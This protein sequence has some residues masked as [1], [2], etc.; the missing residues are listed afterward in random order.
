MGR[1]WTGRRCGSTLGLGIANGMTAIGASHRTD[2]AL[3]GRLVEG[4]MRRGGIFYR[5]GSGALMLAHVAAG[6]L[7]AISS[8]TC[9][10][11]TASRGS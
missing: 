6:R 8:R 9:T 3:I 1:R 7:R 4:L 2:P 11:G 5:N 10:R